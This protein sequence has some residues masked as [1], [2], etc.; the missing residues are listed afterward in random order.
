M[1]KYI[2]DYVPKLTVYLPP[3]MEKAVYSD[4][5]V[6][7]KRAVEEATKNVTVNTRYLNQ[8]Q[9]AEFF[10]CSTTVIK[11]WQQEG[12]RSFKKG[13]EIMFDM[14]DVTK[15]IETLKY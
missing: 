5:F 12:L 13:K 2:D 9:L 15:F 6:L 3:E 7:A 10:T 11:E 4:F 14:E 8:K 1:K